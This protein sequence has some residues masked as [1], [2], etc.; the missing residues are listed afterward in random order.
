MARYADRVNFQPH[1]INN[2]TILIN[3]EIRITGLERFEAELDQD[4][5]SVDTVADGTA[6]LVENPT[7]TGTIKV[8]FLEAAAVTDEIFALLESN[9]TFA[10][11]ALD[12]AAPNF[13]VRGQY[14]KVQKRPAI[15]REAMPSKPEWVFVVPYL[16]IVGG[17]YALATV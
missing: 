8:T 7:R 11:G 6:I 3:D 2:L 10:I 17:S 16:T 15:V 14:C 5:N 4:E 1:N 13:D 9:A 12:E